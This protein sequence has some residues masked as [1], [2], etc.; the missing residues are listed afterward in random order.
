MELL[1]EQ[2]FDL[3]DIYPGMYGTNDACL[4]EPFG[5]II[6]YDYKHG[7]GVPVDVENNP[8]LLYYALGAYLG[9]DCE[10]IELVVVQPRARHV[11]GPVRRWTLTYAELNTWILG[12]LL[13]AAK[14][15]EDPG[16]P[17]VAGDW[18]RFCKASGICRAPIEKQ[19]A[20][21]K[22]QFTDIR[23]PQVEELTLDQMV[24]FHTFWDIF[25]SCHD[26]VAAELQRRLM[27]GES[28]PGYKLVQKKT[29]RRWRDE[30]ALVTACLRY[31]KT[32]ILK[33]FEEPKVLSPAK[34]EKE[35]KKK[36]LS[37]ALESYIE[38]PEGGL[39]MVPESDR[40][41]AV[42]PKALLL[43]QFTDF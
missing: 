42:D 11:D 41:D 20:V 16:A 24:K 26:A 14:A 19:F 4:C 2:P 30:K 35:V 15:T 7:A 34:L 17:L 29:N 36:G 28:I 23:I 8:Q 38:K 18:C 31:T 25:A 33:I 9:T 21:T 1:I 32:G 6:V 40:R 39:T 27:E 13:P 37:I 3:S 43:E 5:K 10:E 22:T 12:A